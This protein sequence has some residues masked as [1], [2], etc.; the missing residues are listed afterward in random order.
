MLKSRVIDD[1]AEAARFIFIRE[2]AA[3]VSEADDLNDES[4]YS[5]TAMVGKQAEKNLVVN[6]L[7][8]HVRKF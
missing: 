7:N 6:V 5:N 1:V 8:K 2:C 3:L 4:T